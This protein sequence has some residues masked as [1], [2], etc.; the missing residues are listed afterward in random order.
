METASAIQKLYDVPVSQP[1]NFAGYLEV[2]PNPGEFAADDVA[3][4]YKK[5]L[6]QLDRN[7]I[8]IDDKETF[9][10]IGDGGMPK[11]KG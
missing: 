9:D 11:S 3:G 2:S 6:V 7:E 10:W 4:G 5:I 8:V 1:L